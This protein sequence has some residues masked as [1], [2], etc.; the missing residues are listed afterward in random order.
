MNVVFLRQVDFC[1]SV[2]YKVVGLV[3]RN[4]RCVVNKCQRV[5]ALALIVHEPEILAYK[6][7]ELINNRRAEIDL[8]QKT[9]FDGSYTSG[10]ITY[11]KVKAGNTLGGIAQR[12]HVT[13]SQL[14]KWNRLKG[15]TIRIGQTL[16][17]YR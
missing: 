6:A 4:F 17:I 10:N 8:A 11:Y 13:V 7:D 1:T 15:T 2:V 12:Y 5:I 9:D 3:V 16:K 14:Q